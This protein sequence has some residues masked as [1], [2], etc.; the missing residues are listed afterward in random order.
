MTKKLSL[1]IIL[2]AFASISCFSQSTDWR[3]WAGLELKRDFRKG[4][5]FSLQA[6]TRFDNNIRHFQ[7]SFFILGGS[8][9]LSKKLGLGLETRF[10]TS[11]ESERFRPGIALEAKDK[12]GK[13]GLSAKLRYQYEFFLQA[14]P[15]IGQNPAVHNIRLK[16]GADYKLSKQLGASFG[17]E[18]LYAV[19]EQNGKLDWIRASTKIEWEFMKRQHLEFGYFYQPNFNRRVIDSNHTITFNYVYELKKQKKRKKK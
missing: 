17:L 12:F 14:I 4:F 16:I 11:R 13:I 7:G 9:K 5:D 1:S 3:A 10:V 18:P 15:E 8:Y 6:Q 2:V 19:S